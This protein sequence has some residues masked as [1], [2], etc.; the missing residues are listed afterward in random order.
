MTPRNLDTT[1]AKLIGC[2]SRPLEVGEG[3]L[4]ACW[5]RN[6]A[7]SHQGLALCHGDVYPPM[8]LQS[9]ALVNESTLPCCHSPNHIYIGNHRQ[10]LVAI[11]P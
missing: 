11:E 10:V 4:G 9:D 6:V 8:H 3:R 7:L 1:L 2:I 5:V